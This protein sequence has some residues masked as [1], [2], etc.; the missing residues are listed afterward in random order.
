MQTQITRNYQLTA[1][2]RA[3]SENA[4]NNKCRRDCGEMRTLSSKGDVVRAT[5]ENTKE[6]L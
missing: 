6:V 5:N 1:V 3:I 2:G 4:A